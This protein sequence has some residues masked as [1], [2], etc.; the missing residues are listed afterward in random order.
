MRF[1]NPAWRPGLGKRAL[2]LATTGLIG[3][4][5][6]AGFGAAVLP[7]AAAGASQP[8]SLNCGTL[9]VS[10]TDGNSYQFNQFTAGTAVAGNG[11]T[12]FPTSAG[13]VPFS[14]LSIGSALAGCSDDY[15]ANDTT[16]NGTVTELDPSFSTLG[17]YGTGN[18][19]VFDVTTDQ[20][21]GAHRIDFSVPPGSTTLVDVTPSADFNGSLDLS[22]VSGN[23]YFGCPTAAPNP[24]NNWNWNN[25]IC[26]S[27]PVANEN[28]SAIDVER[29]DTV[30][31]FSPSLFPTNDTLTV[32]G[33]QGTIV[34]PNQTVTLGSNGQ[35]DGSIFCKWI[36]GHD[37][38]NHDPF[39]GR[40]PRCPHGPNPPPALAEGMPVAFGGLALAAFGFV[41][42][43][44]RRPSGAARS[45]P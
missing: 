1:C 45:D 12:T 8:A 43:R 6:L 11:G 31:N 16:S 21:A 34:A 28:T 5:G 40:V 32:A 19:N 20:L 37:H 3:A 35:F 4:L 38:T 26:G 14:F 15:G 2:C 30:W 44:R 10:G 27:Q 42:Y 33:W 22:A 18:A 25:G 9:E 17:F 39:C 23:I 41:L 36:Y 24:A 29:D 13:A 7:A